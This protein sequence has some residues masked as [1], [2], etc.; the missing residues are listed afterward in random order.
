MKR[1][2][3]EQL[4]NAFRRVRRFLMRRETASLLFITVVLCSVFAFFTSIPS[5][6][7]P[8]EISYAESVSSLKNIFDNPLDA[9]HKIASYIALKLTSSVRATRSVSFIYLFAATYAL[10]YALR[11]WHGGRAG[12]LVA[13]MFSVN[14]VALSSGRLGTT[15]VTLLS[16]F[17]FAGLL[18]WHMHSKSNR[19][20][21]FLVVLSCAALLY[22]PGAPWI[23]TIVAIIYF[24]RIKEFF[25]GVKLSA[26]LS[27]AGA[28]LLIMLP[29]LIAFMR[30]PELVKSWLLLPQSIVIQDVWRQALAVPSAFIF[31]MPVFPLINIARLPVLDI[32]SGFLFL[33]G[34]YAYLKKLKLDRTR[35]MIGVAVVGMLLGALGNVIPGVI[36]LLPFVYSVVAA[37]I[38]YLLDIWVDVFPRN[39]FAIGFASILIALVALGSSYYQLTRFLVV[40]PQ[41][42]E[43]RTIYS[44]PRMLDR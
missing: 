18:L 41:T 6:A 32:A 9:P 27:G 4:Q 43:T 8:E 19:V 15:L 3:T 35:L 2:T 16:W 26:V 31:R 24:N 21:P 40:W 28:G 10:F 29:L 11:R 30:S 17:I 39:P 44:Q 7:A 33:I 22:T 36:L 14:A 5:Q 38:E 34:L 23:I 20:M 12:L 25:Y 37:G 1:V 42:P 13:L